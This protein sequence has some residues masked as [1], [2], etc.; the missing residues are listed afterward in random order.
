[1]RGTFALDF[2]PV[3]KTIIMDIANV[4]TTSKYWGADN[5]PKADS[6]FPRTWQV[7]FRAARNASGTPEPT[8]PP[9]RSGAVCSKVANRDEIR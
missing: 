8:C 4:D 5:P 7:V 6:M 9:Y 3:Q 1:M 2:N